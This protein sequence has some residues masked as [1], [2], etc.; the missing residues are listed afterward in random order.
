LATNVGQ[1]GDGGIVNETDSTAPP[2]MCMI[3]ID[4]NKRSQGDGMG[5]THDGSRLE[6][7]FADL[8]GPLESDPIVEN[9]VGV[10][11]A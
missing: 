1:R 7:V 5:Q 2:A 8:R 10:A 9:C 11:E 3:V 6:N 4:A